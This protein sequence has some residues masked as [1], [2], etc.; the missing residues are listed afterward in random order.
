MKYTSADDMRRDLAKVVDD[1]A[2]VEATVRQ[3]FAKQPKSIKPV[4]NNH[5]KSGPKKA[6]CNVRQGSID[7]GAAIDLMLAGRPVQTSA[8][9]KWREQSETFKRNPDSTTWAAQ[10]RAVAIQHER[11]SRVQARVVDS[12]LPCFRCGAAKGCTQH[13][14]VEVEVS[15]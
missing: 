11:R 1:P 15:A 9:L 5:A 6:P 7:L 2:L 14:C 4:N 12:P 8:D 3:Y 10:D 13:Q